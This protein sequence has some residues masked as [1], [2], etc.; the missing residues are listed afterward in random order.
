MPKPI[1]KVIKILVLSDLA[2]LFG[3]GLV[4]PILAI[5]IIGQIQGGDARVAGMAV[6]I[7]W[8]VKSAL[9]VPISRYLDRNHG[10]KDDYYFLII[11][12]FLASLSPFVGAVFLPAT[13]IGARKLRVGL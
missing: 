9:Q 8:L 11:G 10:E 2:T 13:S 1:N 3:W 6:G 12:T 4:S 5:F 7:Y